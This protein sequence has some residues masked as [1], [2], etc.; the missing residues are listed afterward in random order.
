MTGAAA[1]LARVLEPMG[2]VWQGGLL[3]ATPILCVVGCLIVFL[4]APVG[5]QSKY[6]LIRGIGRI[7][8]LG[9]YFVFVGIVCG[10]VLLMLLSLYLLA[11]FSVQSLK[12][13]GDVP[14][15]SS[16]RIQQDVG[17]G[18]TFLSSEG[19]T[20]VFFPPIK[21]EAVRRALQKEHIETEE[22]GG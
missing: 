8:V 16:M 10:T 19:E 17:D 14:P 20:R 18:V 4:L 9:R 13:S 21:R 15:E 2:F 12:L 11:F 1:V 7:P 22:S 6:T 5:N 3:G